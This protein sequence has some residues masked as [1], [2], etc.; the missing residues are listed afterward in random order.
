MQSLSPSA[1]T[2]ASS[3]PSRAMT[4]RSVLHGTEFLREVS[5]SLRTAIR[6]GRL[7]QNPGR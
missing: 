7:A 6:S 3:C 5:L 4:C 2:A 1:P